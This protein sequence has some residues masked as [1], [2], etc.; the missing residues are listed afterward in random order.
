MNTIAK[1]GLNSL[2][3]KSEEKPH[4][5]AYDDAISKARRE[6]IRADYDNWHMPYYSIYENEPRLNNYQ[7]NRLINN[8]KQRNELQQISDTTIY[9]GQTLVDKPCMLE[10]LKEKGIKTVIDLVGYGKCYE[11]A[12]RNADLDFYTFSIFD[13]WWNNCNHDTPEFIDKLTDFIKKMQE[14]NIYIGC[15]YGSNDTDIAFIL[16]DFFNPQLEGKA[17][18]SIKPSDF[19]LE[20]NTIYDSLSS[21]D[22]KKLGWTKAFEKKLIK[23][24]ISI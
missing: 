11:D 16:N 24:L 9:R 10:Y 7:L 12:V 8:I 20:L 3:F 21:A 2:C 14:G 4:Y 18:T 1:I 15:Q 17:Q 19:A 6:Y 23:K 5:T 13:N 22:K